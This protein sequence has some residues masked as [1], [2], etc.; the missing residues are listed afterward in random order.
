M[1]IKT[2][3][4]V[5][6]LGGELEYNDIYPHLLSVC[7]FV[8]LIAFCMCHPIF[9]ICQF[10]CSYGQIY[11]NFRWLVCTEPGSIKATPCNT[12]RPRATS[13]RKIHAPH[14]RANRKYL[15]LLSNKKVDRSCK[16]DKIYLFVR[17]EI[18]FPQAGA[19]LWWWWEG[20]KP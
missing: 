6:G 14:A 19:I 10:L 15:K 17:N 16:K 11:L 13:V 8:C 20:G 1:T 3:F 4:R 9:Y 2:L 12:A 5:R 7:I 18:I